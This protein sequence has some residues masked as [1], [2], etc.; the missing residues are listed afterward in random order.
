MQDTTEV[1]MQSDRRR[2]ALMVEKMKHK[3]DAVLDLMAGEK[4]TVEEAKVLLKLTTEHLNRKMKRQLLDT[5]LENVIICKDEEEAICIS[6]E[7]VQM[8]EQNKNVAEHRKEI[9]EELFN[10]FMD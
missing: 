10:S 1:I 8:F 4:L 3:V 6:Q 7:R 2:K 9:V 5:P